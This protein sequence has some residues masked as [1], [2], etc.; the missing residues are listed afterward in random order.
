MLRGVRGVFR[1]SRGSKPRF[2]V[3]SRGR[4]SRRTRASFTARAAVGRAKGLGERGP[5]VAALCCRGPVEQGLSAGLLVGGRLAPYVR[6]KG[7]WTEGF[8]RDRVAV[9]RRRA[10]GTRASVS[11]V[12]P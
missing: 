1:R 2:V 10:R 11:R 5:F 6:S 12:L 3:S 8:V 9:L 4:R 7:S